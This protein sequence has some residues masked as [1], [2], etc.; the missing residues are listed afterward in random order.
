MVADEVR[1]LADKTKGAVGNVAQI[2]TE[3]NEKANVTGQNVSSVKDSFTQYIDSSEEVADTI[4][5]GSRQVD[6]CAG[7]L[8]AIS[9]AAQQQTAVAENLS[10]VAENISK[11]TETIGKLLSM[12]P[13]IFAKY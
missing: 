9:S 6:E 7:M 4:R 11:N 2:A 8:E 10:A 13:I 12:R 5:K 3:M 1:K